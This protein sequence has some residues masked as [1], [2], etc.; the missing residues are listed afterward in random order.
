LPEL[1]VRRQ[2]VLTATLRLGIFCHSR[3]VLLLQHPG[4]ACPAQDAK[5]GD[6]HHEHGLHGAIRSSDEPAG[7]VSICRSFDN[8][9]LVACVGSASQV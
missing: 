1:E 8:G 4:N 6:E 9:Q 5:H 3:C 2:A 7:K